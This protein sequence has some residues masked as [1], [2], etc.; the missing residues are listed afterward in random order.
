[1][2][3]L[4]YSCGRLARP[5]IAETRRTV[6]PLSIAPRPATC[7]A[8]SHLRVADQRGEHQNPGRYGS[9]RSPSDARA[10]AAVSDDAVMRI[11]RPVR[12]VLW[13]LWLGCLAFS[14]WAFWMLY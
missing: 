9:R 5:A 4:G 8:A 3:I 6:H 2:D 12:W 11:P 7:L 14:L 10:R 1:M 13:T